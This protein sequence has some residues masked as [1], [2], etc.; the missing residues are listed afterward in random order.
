M[1]SKLE[2]GIELELAINKYEEEEV[3][4]IEDRI[5]R[6]KEVIRLGREYNLKYKN[7]HKHYFMGKPI[8]YST[9]L[10]DALQ[11]LVL[12]AMEFKEQS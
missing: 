8:K 5:E 3:L 6:L 2:L 4:L 1:G 7:P 12:E 10:L 9:P 11:N